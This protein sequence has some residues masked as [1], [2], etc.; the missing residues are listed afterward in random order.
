MY[1]YINPA[2]MKTAVYNFFRDG[3]D[4]LHNIGKEE[5]PQFNGET[6]AKQPLRNIS[7][8]LSLVPAYLDPFR[9]YLLQQ[10]SISLGTI[11]TNKLTLSCRPEEK[12]RRGRGSFG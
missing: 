4:S 12:K 10:V 2:H 6:D 3:F 7:G 8:R 5:K 9:W 11:Y 1:H